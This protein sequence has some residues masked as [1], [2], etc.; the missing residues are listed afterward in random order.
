[1]AQETRE[2]AL[3]RVGAPE[4]LTKK[5]TANHF[6]HF[7]HNPFQRRILSFTLMNPNKKTDWLVEVLFDI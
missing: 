1:M 4:N 3:A 6:Q 5:Q 2:T 7:I